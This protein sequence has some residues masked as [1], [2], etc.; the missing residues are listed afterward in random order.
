MAVFFIN[1]QNRII[2]SGHAEM[3]DDPTSKAHNNLFF[4]IDLPSSYDAE[5]KFIETIKREDAAG[6]YLTGIETPADIEKAAT[7]LRVAE[8]KRG[9]ECSTLAILSEI[10]TP[11]AAL[12]IE[13][14]ARTIPYLKAF[15]F[16]PQKL[17][18]AIGAKLESD[19]I[20]A[21][22]NKI[23][24]AAAVCGIPAFIHLPTSRTPEEIAHT[25]QTAKASGYAGAVV[26]DTDIL[27]ILK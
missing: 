19:A 7:L 5:Q 14:L 8:A 20:Q 27:Q 4:I 12:G 9:K 18:A 13:S 3:R 11:R 15:V 25:W 17:A 23:P 10:A 6:V 26:T 22:G 21:A 24:L 2:E 1:E 16:H